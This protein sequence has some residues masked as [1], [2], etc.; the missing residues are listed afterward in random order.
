MATQD[1]YS[2]EL[3][4]TCLPKVVSPRGS[5]EDQPREGRGGNA[6]D[7]PATPARAP[8]ARL[9]GSGPSAPHRG[10]RPAR[11]RPG[12]NPRPRPEAPGPAPP[13]RPGKRLPG[14]RAD[15][16]R[17]PAPARPLRL[18]H[19][20]PAPGTPR[21]R[22]P[23]AGQAGTAEAGPF[24]LPRD[25]RRRAPAP[26]PGPRPVPARR[27]P[28]PGARARRRRGAGFLRERPSPQTHL[29]PAPPSVPPRHSPFLGHE[30]AGFAACAPGAAPGGDSLPRPPPPPPPPRPGLRLRGLAGWVS[31]G[32]AGS[33]H[34]RR[35][36]PRGRLCALESRSAGGGSPRSCPLHRR[37]D[38]RRPCFCSLFFFFS[39]SFRPFP[40]NSTFLFPPP[41]PFPTAGAGGRGRGGGEG[42]GRGGAGATPPGAGRGG[43]G[44]AASAPLPRPP[45]RPPRGARSP[46]GPVRALPARGRGGSPAGTALRGPGP[47]RRFAP[48]RAPSTG[49]TGAG[50]LPWPQAGGGRASRLY[51][52]RAEGAPQSA[53]SSRACASLWRARFV[54]TMGAGVSTRD[55]GVLR[56]CRE[57][58][59]LAPPELP[60]CGAPGESSAVLAVA[61]SAGISGWGLRV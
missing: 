19:T 32:A 60:G 8:R 26:G 38:S 53:E 43:A 48:L 27:P 41:S 6:L 28:R 34:G 50:L 16:A 54:P 1:T 35:R 45:R 40:L 55:R 37:P 9:A 42:R 47:G 5:P 12:P 14:A 30:S 31:R 57:T 36:S 29:P 20:P 4:G 17:R 15:D 51:R 59:R 2:S 25:P 18:H 46:P 3:N 33:D 49:L 23:R 56:G 24:R 61:A 10:P 7:S 11:T 44:R 13:R 22:K 58:R 52:R 39:P 21:P